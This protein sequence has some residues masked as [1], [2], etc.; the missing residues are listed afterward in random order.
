MILGVG[1]DRTYIIFLGLTIWHI[2]RWKPRP[3]NLWMR[4]TTWKRW[5]F[6]AVAGDIG[7]DF[8]WKQRGW[9]ATKSHVNLCEICCVVSFLICCLLC[10]FCFFCVCGCVLFCIV[11]F[12]CVLL[13]GGVFC[14]SCCSCLFWVIFWLFWYVCF[15]FLYLLLFASVA[16]LRILFHAWSFQNDLSEAKNISAFDWTFR[17]GSF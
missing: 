3:A 1:V 4:R 9:T 16:F 10:C 11:W 13:S 15:A 6:G 5:G 2:G 7:W 14:C 12:S 17:S 8:L